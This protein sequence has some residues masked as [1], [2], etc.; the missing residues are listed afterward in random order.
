MVVPILQV[1]W[2]L[3]PDPTAWKTPHFLLPRDQHCPGLAK[4]RCCNGFRVAPVLFRWSKVVSGKAP[5]FSLR[6][7]SRNKTSAT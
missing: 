7:E 6:Y 3:W 5:C 1:L 4:I 2:I